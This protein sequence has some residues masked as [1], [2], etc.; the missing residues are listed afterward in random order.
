M[1]CEIQPFD[2][3]KSYFDERQPRGV[4]LSG[5]PETVTSGDT[6]RI[7]ERLLELEIP[8]LGI[9]YGMQALAAQ[10]GGGV[11]SSAHREFGHAEIDLH[12]GS[13]LLG[14]LDPDSHGKA[15]VWMS[16]GDKVTDLPEG[17]ALPLARRAP[18]LRQWRIRQNEFTR[19]N[20]IQR[21]RIPQTEII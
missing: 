18:R 2:V 14:T 10:L 17:L 1:Y 3:E 15:Q 8:I 6:P 16:H 11:K 20:F 4:I 21:L 12:G 9:C 19:F 7:P 5:G 13:E